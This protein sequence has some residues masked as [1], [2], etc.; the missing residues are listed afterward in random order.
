MT[1]R[2]CFIGS[3]TDT[4]SCFLTR[5]LIQLKCT[6]LPQ[7]LSKYQPV[8]LTPALKSRILYCPSRFPSAAWLSD[9]A[10]ATSWTQFNDL[11]HRYRN[12]GKSL[13]KDG[14]SLEDIN[15]RPRLLSSFLLLIELP[16]YQSVRPDI[17]HSNNQ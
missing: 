14:V 7:M 1:T 16:K 8:S 4:L 5:L 13:H 2:S 10:S 6:C 11:S 17:S 3:L 12:S 9:A 15:T